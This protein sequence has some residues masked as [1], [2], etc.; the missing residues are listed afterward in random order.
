M[1]DASELPF[2]M[3]C[4]R[5]NTD[6]CYTPMFNVNSFVSCPEYRSSVWTTCKD[7]RPLFVQLA[8][9]DPIK[10]LEAAKMVENSCD[11][12]DINFGSILPQRTNLIISVVAVHRP[13]LAE[14]TTAPFYRISGTQ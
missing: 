12:V 3:M 6:L 8:G 7:D 9:D 2:R 5:Y 1:V 13:S 14:V 10:M 11:A 4:R